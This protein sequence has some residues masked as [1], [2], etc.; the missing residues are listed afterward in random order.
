LRS[1]GE[2]NN[3]HDLFLFSG[4]PYKRPHDYNF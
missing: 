3:R 2:G 1:I 4:D